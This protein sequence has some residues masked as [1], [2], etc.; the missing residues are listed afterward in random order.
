M[1]TADPDPMT[2]D[3]DEDGV[4]DSRGY[5]EIIKTFGSVR[6]LVRYCP[7][8]NGKLSTG[9]FILSYCRYLVSY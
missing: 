8:D 9:E 5:G 1:V 3:P 7:V 2:S 6:K 4:D